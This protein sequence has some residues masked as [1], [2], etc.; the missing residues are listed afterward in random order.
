MWIH[1]S[2]FSPTVGSPKSFAMRYPAPVR[3]L[4]GEPTTSLA[5]CA[6]GLAGPNIRIA[7]GIVPF[8]K[9]V[10]YLSL[11]AASHR[12]QGPLRQTAGQNVADGLLCLNELWESVPVALDSTRLLPVNF[13]GRTAM[14]SA[15]HL[16]IILH[17]QASPPC[18]IPSCTYPDYSPGACPAPALHLRM[19][20]SLCQSWLFV[21]AVR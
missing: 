15:P 11:A 13:P 3:R 16:R 12:G 18:A 1:Y 4:D 2:A 6:L 19:V 5:P 10:N 8:L 9:G 14:P 17:V 21:V 20:R 7:N